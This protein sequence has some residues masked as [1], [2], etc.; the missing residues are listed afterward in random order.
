MTTP[1]PVARDP[2]QPRPRLSG[3]FGAL[4]GDKAEMPP[5]G[6]YHENDEL[7]RRGRGKRE[8]SRRKRL[9]S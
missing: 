1:A 5:C 6:P 8:S 7:I 9:I 2:D 4:S 3:K